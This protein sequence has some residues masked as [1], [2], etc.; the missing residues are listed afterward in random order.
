VT[1]V[2]TINRTPGDYIRS[3]RH[4]SLEERGAYQDI[5]DQ[6]VELGQDEDPP[7][8]PDDDKSLA[9]ILGCTPARWRQIKRRLC[10]GPL[11]VLIVEGGRISQGRIVE[12]IEAARKR[13][14][15][16]S[17]GGRASGESRRRKA[18]A[19]RERMTNGRST[20][21]E[22]IGQRIANGSGNGSRT[23]GEP[24]MSH[25]S[26]V[27][28]TEVSSS[29]TSQPLLELPSDGVEAVDVVLR[30][31]AVVAPKLPPD[32]IGVTLWLR[33]INADPWWIAAALCEANVS[34]AGVRSP[35]YVTTILQ[36][37]K[38]DGWDCPDAQGYVAYALASL[39]RRRDAAKVGA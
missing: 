21:V 3:T 15:G 13:I 6:I 22:R 38:A 33:D 20:D 4:L 36:N 25:E 16:A 24:V 28:K 8:L 27:T 35:K 37:R 11:A 2:I 1:K 34:L 7:S 26:R 10:T 18:A 12:E 9:G 29:S 39:Q 30:T 5:L 32:E 23:D 14:D 17:T 19:L 31:L